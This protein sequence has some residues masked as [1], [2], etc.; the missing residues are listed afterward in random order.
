MLGIRHGL[1]SVGPG[2][3]IQ[4]SSLGYYYMQ[5]I[6]HTTVLSPSLLY[7]LSGDAKV[8]ASHAIAR[9]SS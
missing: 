7:V 8:S 3:L 1:C 9:S 4:Y 5:Y 6:A 2:L